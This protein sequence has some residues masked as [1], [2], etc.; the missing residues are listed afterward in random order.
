[1]PNGGRGSG[2]GQPGQRETIWRGERTDP[3]LVIRQAVALCAVA[4]VFIIIILAAVL[5]NSFENWR[6]FDRYVEAN[7]RWLVLIPVIPWPVGCV[8]CIIVLWYEIFDPNY[9]APRD[10]LSTSRIIYPW[11]R[12]R[13][14]PPAS[15]PIPRARGRIGVDFSLDGDDDN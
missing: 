4:M 1:M 11:S 2:F 10:A 15:A 5:L 13:I 6:A 14:V 9:P 12:E 8:V 7:W 3:R